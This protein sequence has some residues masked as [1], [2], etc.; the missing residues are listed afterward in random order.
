MHTIHNQFVHNQ[1]VLYCCGLGT[2]RRLCVRE[3]HT[4]IFYGAENR[5]LNVKISDMS[6]T[7]LPEAVS[8]IY[9]TDYHLF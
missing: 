8:F 7:D 4:N 2:L 1:F 5:V 3:D 9:R 6:A